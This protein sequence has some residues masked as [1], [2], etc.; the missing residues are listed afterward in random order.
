MYARAR[1]PRCRAAFLVLVGLLLWVVQ[2]PSAAAA[3]SSGS[4]AVSVGRFDFMEADH[5]AGE[6]CLEYR[7]R[8]RVYGLAPMVGISANDDSA[9]WVYAGLGREFRFGRRW[10]V[11]PYTGVAYYERGDSKDLGE[12][13]EF[14]SGLEL[15]YRLTERSRVGLTYYHMS[16]AGLSDKNPGEESF[17]LVLRFGG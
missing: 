9:W 13:F 5:R 11:T 1:S 12:A 17:L 2:S 8:A 3:G 6:A 10:G 7:L 16:N 15:D 14:R 4:F